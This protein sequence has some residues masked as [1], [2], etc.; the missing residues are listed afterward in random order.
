MFWTVPELR[1]GILNSVEKVQFYVLCN[2]HLDYT[3]I[4]LKSLLQNEKYH[5]HCKAITG[6]YYLVS[7]GSEEIAV[8]FEERILHEKLPSELTFGQAVLKKSFIISNLRNR[9]C[10]ETC[11]LHHQWRPNVKAW[12]CVRNA[13]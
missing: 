10:K 1:I 7:W 5:F 3:L 9:V 12:L 6:N 11:A 13:S 4:I 2:K 8:S